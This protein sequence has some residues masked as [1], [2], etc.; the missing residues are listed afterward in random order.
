MAK[1]P[2]ISKKS[3]IPVPKRIHLVNGNSSQN[4]N[5]FFRKIGMPDEKQVIK[6][7]ID[8]IN[9]MEKKIGLMERYYTVRKKLVDQLAIVGFDVL[10]LTESMVDLQGKIWELEEKLKLED[11]NPLESKEWLEARKQLMAEMQFIHK[12]GLN[13]ID[14]ESKVQTRKAML[15]DDIAFEI[16]VES[17]D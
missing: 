5:G 1:S 14:I 4:V 11:K 13:A 12:Q 6:L 17:E 15:N 16:E 8:T 3:K 2:S 9:D 7:P 10:N